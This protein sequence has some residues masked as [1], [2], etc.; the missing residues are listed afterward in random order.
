MTALADIE[1]A[2]MQRLSMLRTGTA[3]AFKT[4]EGLGGQSKARATEC[5]QARRKPAA[6]VR[7]AGRKVSSSGEQTEFTIYVACESLRGSGEART[8]GDGVLGMHPLLD[9]ARGNLD[10]TALL[11]GCGLTLVSESAVSDD[12]RM[13]VFQQTYRIEETS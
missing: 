8:G 11:C 4:I 5:L 6:V 7:Y 12:D 9:L 10:G 13:L 3:G 2:L 1:S